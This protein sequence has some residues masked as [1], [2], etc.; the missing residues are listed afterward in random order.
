[1]RAATS[2]LI[3][4]FALA[5]LMLPAAPALADRIDGN[6]CFRDGRSMSIDGPAIV[7]PGGTAMTGDY[8]RHGF[9]YVVPAGEAD[10][11]AQVDMVQ[12]DDNTIQVTTSGGGPFTH[13]FR[14]SSNSLSIAA[15]DRLS[16]V[17]L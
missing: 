12:F 5:A 14:V 10:A 6:W 9:R 16:A 1:M 3:F 8:D 17:S 7:T 13:Y 2:T 4:V 11:R 15:Q